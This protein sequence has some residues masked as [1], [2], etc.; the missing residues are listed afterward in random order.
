[1]FFKGSRY[2]DIPEHE[3]TDSRGR[4]IRYKGMRLIPPTP[5]RLGH[6]TTAGER[7]EHIAYRHYRDPELFWRICDANSAR[8]P[9]DLTAEMG[10]ILVIPLG[11]G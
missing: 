9:E 6:R 7:L 8:W 2:T 10:R 1:M 11:R 3:I 5:G 4:V